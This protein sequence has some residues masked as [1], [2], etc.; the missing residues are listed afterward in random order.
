MKWFE[1]IE[2]LG[3][4]SNTVRRFRTKEAAQAY[5]EREVFEFE[6]W[7]CY[8]VGPLEEVDTEN[9]HFFQEDL[10]AYYERLMNKGK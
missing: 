5:A 2:D 10:E 7:D 1:F 9:G 8:P 3:D 6:D 4:G